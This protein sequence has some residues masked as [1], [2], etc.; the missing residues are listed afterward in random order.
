MIQLP[1]T[2]TEQLG[3]GGVVKF[4]SP[5]PVIVEQVGVGNV[6]TL[7]GTDTFT[8][9][10]VG[11]YLFEN[12][13]DCAGF[14]EVISVGDMTDGCCVAPMIG[15][16][17]GLA[18]ITISGVD[19]PIEDTGT[20]YT[21]ALVGD[22]FTAT[23]S[24]GV[25]QTVTIV[26]P[27]DTDTLLGDPVPN[28]TTGIVTWPVLDVDG[29]PTGDT[30]TGDFSGFLS[31]PHPTV[32]ASGDATA[33]F[34]AGANAW[35]I[36]FV[37][38]DT[39]TT[40]TMTQNA[41]GDTVLTPSDGG[42]PQI[43]SN[44]DTDV[45]N[46]TLTQNGKSLRVTV[47]EDGNAVVGELVIPDDVLRDCTDK[48][49]MYDAND[50]WVWKPIKPEPLTKTLRTGTVC[51]AITGAAVDVIATSTAPIWEHTATITPI[52]S[53]AT[54]YDEEY[55]LQMYAGNP[56]MRIPTAGD[57]W[58]IKLAATTVQ[59]GAPNVETTNSGSTTYIHRF[60]PVSMSRTLQRASTSVNRTEAIS[61]TFSNSSVYT[62]N[63]LNTIR[64]ENIVTYQTLK[65]VTI[66]T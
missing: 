64:I 19:Y 40:Y 24:D 23:D 37:D 30:R 45:S 16:A 52:T 3:V 4:R 17:G 56:Y 41:A 51:P 18:G 28:A 43:I 12:T 9:P 63:P 31:S 44:T 38:T 65:Q 7:T 22:E 49:L 42:A 48:A 1:N 66:G 59:I 39:D 13:C 25:V 20:T 29:N 60:S 61:W 27:D 14:Y 2:T 57:R 46:V 55:T 6:A 32:A 10:A 35:V 33:T 50:G 8:A 5:C 11:E 21:Y 62:P 53:N 15:A 58:G 47:T 26:H 54:C 36:G 34:D